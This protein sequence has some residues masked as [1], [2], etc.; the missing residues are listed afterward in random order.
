M[1]DMAPPAA[2][3]SRAVQPQD[4]ILNKYRFSPF[5][6]GASD[7]LERLQAPRQAGHDAELAALYQIFTD[8]MDTDMI[9]AR[10]MKGPNGHSS[11]S[12]Q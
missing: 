7:L 12:Q 3:S 11:R 9:I 5:L 10:L 4:E 2:R 6:P 8:L 1:Q